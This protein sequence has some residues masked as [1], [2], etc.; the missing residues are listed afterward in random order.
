MS[1]QPDRIEVDLDRPAII[2]QAAAFADLRAIV[3]EQAGVDIEKSDAFRVLSKP[4]KKTG[5]RR[6]SAYVAIPKDATDPA[7]VMAR[8]FLSP[9]GEVAGWMAD[10][11]TEA[12]KHGERAVFATPMSSAMRSS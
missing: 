1:R 9:F 2:D 6:M 7:D 12:A 3:F 10:Q 8:G 5:N 11:M 4:I